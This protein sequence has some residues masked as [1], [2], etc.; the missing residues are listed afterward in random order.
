MICSFTNSTISSSNTSSYI[1]WSEKQYTPL[2][3]Y[4]ACDHKF[5]QTEQTYTD[6]PLYFFY[7]HLQA[8]V[9]VKI[10]FTSVFN[11]FPTFHHF[12]SSLFL[13]FLYISLF[14]YCIY[15]SGFFLYSLFLPYRQH[16]SNFLIFH[17]TRKHKFGS[18]FM[19]VCKLQDI[20]FSASILM[21]YAMVR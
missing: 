2:L 20:N 18:S 6:V 21:V 7:F 11:H 12:Y 3:P 19:A 13:S 4:S 5:L 10:V 1:D 8:N 14:N 15:I 16:F 9:G 17:F